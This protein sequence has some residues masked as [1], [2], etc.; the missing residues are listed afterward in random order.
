MFRIHIDAA[1]QGP[2]IP[3][4][5]IVYDWDPGALG[6]RTIVVNTFFYLLFLENNVSV[7]G[8]LA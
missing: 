8:M 1:S 6:L 5:T 4:Y 3:L 2:G 7:V